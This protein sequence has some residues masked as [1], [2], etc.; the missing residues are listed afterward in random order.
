MTKKHIKTFFSHPCFVLD[1]KAWWLG[2]I[3]FLLFDRSLLMLKGRDS[4]RPGLLL[5]HKF[6][7]FSFLGWDEQMGVV[8]GSREKKRA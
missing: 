7:D 5:I 3:G 1:N 4:D 6:R 8:I 2:D